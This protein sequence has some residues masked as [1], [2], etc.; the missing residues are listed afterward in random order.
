MASRWIILL[1][2]LGLTAAKLTGETE[3]D[4]DEGQDWDIFNINEEAGLDLLEGDIEQDKSEGRNSII[5]D[6]YRWPR[7]VPYYLEDSL[8]MNA[9]GVI[10]K[11]FDQYRLKTCIDFTPW[12]GE[13]NYISVYKGSGCF[14]SV[15]NRR[16]GKQRLSI[17]RNCDRLGTVEHEFLHAL[18]FWHEQSRAD[19]DDYVNIMWDRIEP[20]KEH[21][22]NTYDDTVSSALD[23]PYD[24]GSV[25]HYSKTAFNIAS[26]PTIVTKIPQFMDVIGQRM[27]F[28]DSDLLKL[29]RL[30]NC[31]TSSTFVDT[32]N[33]EREN[34][35][36]MIQG[37]GGNAKWE[38]RSS[39]TG[40]PQTDF[41][42]MG[43]CKGKGYFMH[44]NTASG[45]AGDHA[46]LESR[47][48]YPKP[49]PQCLQF[50]LHNTGAA[51]DVLNI[52]VREYDKLNPNGR[53]KLFK[54]I[55]GGVWGSWEL[56][57]VNLDVKTK[58]RVV[59][60]GVKGKGA[61]TGG[62]SLDD[63]NLS[64]TSCPQHIWHIRN[65]TA[66]LATTP[67][68]TKVYSPPFL[69]P[70]GYSFQVGVYLN[71]LSDR[72]GYMAVYFY[73][74]SGPNDDKLKWPCPWQQ[75]TMALMDQQSDI[76]K[77]MS[78]HRMVTTDP[79]KLSSDGTEFY[80]DNPRKVGSLVSGSDGSQYYRGPGTGTS[81][82]LTHSRLRSRNFIK[83]D[84][85]FFLLSL[86]DISELLIPQPLPRAAVHGD[87]YLVKGAAQELPQGT[88]NN[89]TVVTAVTVSAAV[90]ILVVGM[91]IGLNAWRGRGRRQQE[92]NEVVIIEDMPGFLDLSCTPIT[93]LEAHERKEM[94]KAGGPIA[95]ILQQALL[96]VVSQSNGTK[97]GCL[98]RFDLQSFDESV[99]PLLTLVNISMKLMVIEFLA[100]IVLN[101]P[102]ANSPC[103]QDPQIIRLAD[104]AI[105]SLMEKQQPSSSLL[106]PQEVVMRVVPK[107]L[108]GFWINPAILLSVPPL[109]LSDLANKVR[110]KY[111]PDVLLEELKRFGPELLTRIVD[112]TVGEICVMFEPQKQVLTT[113]ENLESRNKSRNEAMSSGS[114]YLSSSYACSPE[115]PK[116]LPD[117]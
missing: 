108:Q 26:D 98:W 19:R 71:G 112:V 70:A 91:L 114:W 101:S 52:L 46:F 21:N 116:I 59:F 95:D 74:T 6:Q 93:F 88:T 86:D 43:Q 13:E 109:Q 65:I 56:H 1:F 115:F 106:N 10:L 79:K 20:G 9:K 22:F 39:V 110:E 33:F 104:K 69:S 92:T 27:E 8:E 102:E 28:S 105:R 51:D 4:V 85:A 16:V 94:S 68:G 35:C 18:G 60:E 42:N 24:Y 36:G 53:L 66:L 44:F 45:K 25:M 96:P 61:A 2:G 73:L 89:P 15:G 72:P 107:V 7:T 47:I 48:L 90:A 58:S 41:T 31:T 100:R 54:S 49:G 111:T 78:M 67:A 3:T 37:P 99:Q 75:V 12:K 38:Q 62:F 113:K 77:Q 84:D 76:R 103:F 11:A 117:D 83:G 14:S 23:V 30:Y 82:F 57:Y 29:N 55:S 80:W 40:G 87:D 64:S 5:G 17:G 50:F 63:I 97:P 32:C 34:I 81:T